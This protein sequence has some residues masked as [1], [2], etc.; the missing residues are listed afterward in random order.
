MQKFIAMSLNVIS[1]FTAA[2][3]YNYDW[4]ILACIVLAGLGGVIYGDA[5]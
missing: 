4:R 3:I 2:Q 5:D 1:S